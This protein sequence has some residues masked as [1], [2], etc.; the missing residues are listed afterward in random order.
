MRKLFKFFTFCLAIYVLFWFGTVLAD[1]ELLSGDLI[2][3]HVVAASDSEEDQALKLQVRDAIV[4][5]L[6]SVMEKLPSVDEAKAYIMENVDRLQEIANKVLADAG[7]SDKAAVSLTQESFDTREYDTFSL[8]AGVYES[9]RIN[10][11]DGEGQ[12]WWCVVFPTLCLGT[13]NEEFA[14]TAAGSGFEDSLTGALQQEETYEVRFF[15]LD[16]L[17][18]IQNFFHRNR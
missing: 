3:L 2:R 18:R 6:S 4:E 8:P 17:G 9:L 16:F 11:G 10:I 7:C 5:E 12:N 1:R 14:V 13:T 15:V